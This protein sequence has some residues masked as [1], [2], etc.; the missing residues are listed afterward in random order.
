MIYI[1]VMQFNALITLEAR[2]ASLARN[3]SSAYEDM[4]HM[5]TDVCTSFVKIIQ[6]HDRNTL[7]KQIPSTLTASV[8][9]IM[10]KY[11]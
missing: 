6:H 8:P 7:S 4:G 9:L 2:Y 10:K 1:R 3:I 11:V 5:N